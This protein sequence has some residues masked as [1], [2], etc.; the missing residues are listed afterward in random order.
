MGPAAFREESG[1]MTIWTR[2]RGLD[3]AGNEVPGKISPHLLTGVMAEVTAGG[4]T[5]AQGLGNLNTL[6]GVLLDATEI[7][8]ATTLFNALGVT[9]TRD[10]VDDVLNLAEMI[11]VPYD[12]EASFD[13]RLGL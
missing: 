4:M 11:A 9:L 3:A 10:E 2:M 8:Q 13:T 1:I 7:A 12:V 6:S 5:P